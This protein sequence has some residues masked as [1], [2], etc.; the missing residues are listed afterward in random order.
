ML[1]KKF[2]LPRE[3]LTTAAPE[4]T[5]AMLLDKMIK[6]DFHA[7]VV[8][9]GDA[10][11]PVGIVTKSDMIKAYQLGLDPKS[12]KAKEVMGTI[13]ETVLDTDS[14]DAAAKHFED[15][16]HRNAFVLNKDN[17]FVGMLSALDVAIECAR[18]DHAWPWNR[19][20]L[21]KKYK[22]PSPPTSPKC[23]I[24][25]P[26]ALPAHTFEEISGVTEQV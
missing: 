17:H 15:T 8:T 12:H 9:T 22:I 10:D 16:Q 23:A 11:L 21:S 18:D 25:G 1:V 5:V 3:R 26:V 6:N 24:K 19:D 2:M 14:R 13:L 4:E 20:A 7:I